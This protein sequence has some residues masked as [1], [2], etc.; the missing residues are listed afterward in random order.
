VVCG[1]IWLVVS[2]SVG[3]AQEPA[4][5]FLAGLRQRG[6]FDFA[7]RYL[8]QAKTSPLV[9][10]G[11]RARIEFEQ[12][13]TLVKQGE[14]TADRALRERL[15]SEAQAR[16]KAYVA[17][18]ASGAV[19]AAAQ[20]QIA[21]LDANEARRKLASAK[22]QP[23]GPQRQAEL[24]EAQTLYDRALAAL[25]EAIEFYTASLA[26]PAAGQADPTADRAAQR[27]EMVEAQLLTGIYNFEKAETLPEGSA[28]RRR[29]LTE[30]ADALADLHAAYRDWVAGIYA[31]LYEG[32]CFQELEQW[33][34]AIGCFED[35]AALRSDESNSR[36]LVVKAILHLAETYIARERFDEAIDRSRR[37]LDAATPDERAQPDGLAVAYLAA[38]ATEKKALA[39]PVESPT[40]RSLVTSAMN[41]ARPVA[42]ATGQR[43]MEARAMLL[44][45]DEDAESTQPRT[46]E[47]ALAAGREAIDFTQTLST[48][49][50]LARENNPDGVE[51]LQQQLEDYRQAARSALEL[52]LRLW[53]AELDVSALNDARYL[54]ARLNLASQRYYDAAMMG[55][56]I[57][58]H[59]PDDAHAREGAQIALAAFYE[60]YQR[61]PGDGAMS[62]GEAARRFAE[63]RLHDIGELMVARWPGEREGDDA[64]LLLVTLALRRGDVERAVERAQAIS[65][66]RRPQADLRIG[67]GLWSNYLAALRADAATRPPADQLTDWKSQAIERLQTGL[68][69]VANE[70]VDATTATAALSLAQALLDDQRFDEAIAALEE[71]PTGALALI[72][73]GS[74]A[75]G[76]DAF[77]LEAYKAGLRAAVGARPLRNERAKTLMDR[78]EAH[79]RRSQAANGQQTLLAIYSGLGRQ[80]E[81]S[82]ERSAAENDSRQLELATGVFEDILSRIVRLG[83]S[84]DRNTNHWIAQTYFKLGS[85]LADPAQALS[86]PAREYFQK[87]AAVYQTILNE[88]PPE[89][90]NERR[91]ARLKLAECHQA[92]GQIQESIDMLVEILKE[93]PDLLQVQIAAARAYQLRGDAEGPQWYQ[94]AIVGE[95]KDPGTQTNLVW[96]WRKVSEVA[97]QGATG[98]PELRE[99][100]QG[101]FYEACFNIADCQ[102]RWATQLA[103]DERSARLDV[104]K[105][106]IRT[107]LV[108]YP[109]LGGDVWRTRFDELL[110]R[111]QLLRGDNPQ[112]LKEFAHAAAPNV[113]L[114][115]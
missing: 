65:P 100:L 68:A 12:A 91:I 77:I 33:E 54:L 9:D 106:Y 93:Q 27:A 73:D 109:T 94:V 56:F 52:S 92:L 25:A 17:A 11:F 29:L 98:R 79:T 90:T 44:R 50:V 95:L 23:A 49:L 103:G 78:L 76:A 59:Y 21:S 20:K 60:I 101:M 19:K 104:A 70:R 84:Q 28:A 105:E 8:E 108:L 53:T 37:W 22:R 30:T 86:P 34:K 24:T 5:E 64:L 112:G 114:R 14:A 51:K 4:D 74:P 47:E 75:A 107:M 66:P 97:R 113:R 43:Q 58:Q 110:Q 57:A 48:A 89:A 82:M 67:L 46:F 71:R 41:L 13:L 45:L 3:A 85:R 40:R 81:I 96:G 18:G 111:I 87:S 69:G 42:Q 32:R 55:E 39:L 35:I 63:E 2:P 115:V 7:M 72:E 38:A 62:D 83:E 10:D 61:A 26:A 6:L 1:L 99:Q 80:L 36:A 16:L 31:H 88:T 15:L 102:Y